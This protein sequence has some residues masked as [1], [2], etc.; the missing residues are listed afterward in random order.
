VPNVVIYTN[1]SYCFF[2]PH[3]NSCGMVMTFGC[4]DFVFFSC[5]SSSDYMNLPLLNIKMLLIL[6]DSKIFVVC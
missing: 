6:A 3:S 5:T 4:I 2:F 1:K